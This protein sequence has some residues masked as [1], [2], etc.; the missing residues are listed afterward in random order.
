MGRIIAHHRL[1]MSADLD[2]L[3]IFAPHFRTTK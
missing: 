1:P 2:A 3:P